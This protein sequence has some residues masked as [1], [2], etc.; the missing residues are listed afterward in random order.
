M[1]DSSYVSNIDEIIIQG[2]KGYIVKEKYKYYDNI[3]LQIE[4]A[5]KNHLIQVEIC[6]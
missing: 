5:Q 6:H 4:V 2:Y 3:K 1:R